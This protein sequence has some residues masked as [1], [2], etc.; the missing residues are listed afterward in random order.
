MIASANPDIRETTPSQAG[1]CLLEENQ[2]W[3]S[4]FDKALAS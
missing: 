4:W 1:A 3:Q 2:R